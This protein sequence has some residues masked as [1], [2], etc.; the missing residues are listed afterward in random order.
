MDPAK[1]SF[2]ISNPQH[3]FMLATPPPSP[4]Q[5]RG[6]AR[7]AA[8]FALLALAW[9]SPAAYAQRLAPKNLTTYDHK[10][11]HFGFSVGINTMDFAFAYSDLFLARVSATK[12]GVDTVFG[13]TNHRSTGFHLGPLA[14]FR[15]GDY[16][17][18][19]TQVNLSF[20]Q[21]Q[22]D[23]RLLVDTLGGAPRFETH[24]MNIESIYL[25]FPLLIKY[26]SMRLNNHRVYLVG[27]INPKFD[28]VAEK[29]VPDEEL[30]KIKLNSF[31]VFA[32]M[33][34]GFDFYLP[35]FKFA[36]E[37]KFGMGLLDAPVPDGSQFTSSFSRMRSK[38]FMLT[39][40]FE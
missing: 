8:F 1:G 11:L 36:T 21:R 3:R 9:L 4:T 2:K 30:P 33:G 40:H 24:S 10:P 7:S 13:V 15:V 29:E 31:D 34:L 12:L 16:L 20:G 25:E 27:G 22:L 19:R 23:Y 38:M 6:L 39:F 18:L 17:D 32:E 28:M 5:S 14:N 37:L 35:Y 26:K